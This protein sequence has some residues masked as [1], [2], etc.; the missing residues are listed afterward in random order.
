MMVYHILGYKINLSKW[1][2]TEIIH[3]TLFD[4]KRFKLEMNLSKNLENTKIF[5]RLK[6]TSKNF[7]G[8]L[9]NSEPCRKGRWGAFLI[10]SPLQETADC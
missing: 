6:N 8:H 5:L 9:R 10:L 7:M 3:S 2:I 4:Q 1:K